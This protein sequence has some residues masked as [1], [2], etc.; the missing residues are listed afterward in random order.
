MCFSAGASFAS[1]IVISAIG[2]ATLGKVSKPAQKLFAVIPLL[3][4]LQQFTEGVLW[5]TL[6][7][8]GG[9]EGLQNAATYIFLITALIIWPVLLPLSMW[10]MEKVKTR[11]KI[12]AVLIVAGSISS[13]FYGFCLIFYNVTPQI[14]FISSTSII[15]LGPLYRSSLSSTSLQLLHRF[16]SRLSGGRG[17]LAF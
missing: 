11:K 7:S 1:G 14:P 3:F 8:S 17:C 5:I 9:Y 12:L 13:L 16:L 4:G 2:I 6:R 15:S 10:F